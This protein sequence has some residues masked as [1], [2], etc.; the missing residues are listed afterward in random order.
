MIRAVVLFHA[1][2]ASYAADNDYELVR[3]EASSEGRCL[4]GTMG[5]YY[6]KQGTELSSVVVHLEGG[7]W[8]YN[9]RDCLARSKTSIGSSS[10]WASAGVPAMDGGA[11]GV[12]S[13]DKA[14]NP[15]VSAALIL[16]SR[17]SY[18]AFFSSGTGRN[19][20]STIAMARVLQG[21]DRPL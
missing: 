6:W 4:D 18:L 5:G 15:D 13:S 10:G 2:V 19:S 12:L 16:C 8:C 1:L 17:I 3:F 14:Q 11:N 21:L 7:G 20:T 9:E